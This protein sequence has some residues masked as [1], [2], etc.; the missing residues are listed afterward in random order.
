VYSKEFF[1]SGGR[2]MVVVVELLPDALA[3]L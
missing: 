2:V 1:L 3:L